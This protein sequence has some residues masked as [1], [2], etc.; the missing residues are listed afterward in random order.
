M[1][2]RMPV[3]VI[4]LAWCAAW[5]TGTAPAQEADR[6]S[7]SEQVLREDW[8]FQ[9]DGSPRLDRTIAELLWTERLAA[10]LQG[11]ENPPE[12]AAELSALGAVREKIAGVT[13]IPKEPPVG[14][15]SPSAVPVETTGEAL[16]P[17]GPVE[18]TVGCWIRSQGDV[19]DVLGSGPSSGDFLLSSIAARSARTT[20]PT[21]DRTR[22]TA[23]SW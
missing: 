12:L 5:W 17:R 6:P 20:S 13:T 15:V 18:Y 10:R 9:A 2:R 7:Q 4:C 22:W 1:N 16:S 3:I 19:M 23:R 11:R 14:A 8:L 21:K